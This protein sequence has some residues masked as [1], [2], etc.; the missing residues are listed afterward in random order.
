MRAPGSFK[1]EIKGVPGGPAR[2]VLGDVRAVGTVLQKP[3]RSQGIPPGNDAHFEGPRGLRVNAAH[4]ALQS[5]HR[6]QG[7]SLE[8]VAVL[9]CLWCP[10]LC[11]LHQHFP[12]T[13]PVSQVRWWV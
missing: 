7:G 11:L 6:E 12:N 9:S 2:R 8:G 3:H 10:A 5:P 1:G 13:F 4:G